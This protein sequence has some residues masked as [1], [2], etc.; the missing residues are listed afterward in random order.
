MFSGNIRYTDGRP[1]EFCT[2]SILEAALE[3]LQSVAGVTLYGAFEHEFQLQAPPWRNRQGLQRS[4]G[5]RRKTAFSA[6]R[7]SRQCARLA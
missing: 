3:R 5:S 6:R 1:W 7:S 2:R 4:E